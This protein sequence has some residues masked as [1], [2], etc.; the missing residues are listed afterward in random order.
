MEHSAQT[1]EA[2]SHLNLRIQKLEKKKSRGLEQEATLNVKSVRFGGVS[3]IKL[4]D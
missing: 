2:L 1:E 4:K 3:P